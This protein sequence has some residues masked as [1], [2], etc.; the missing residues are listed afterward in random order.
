VTQN[1]TYTSS[2]DELHLNN[3]EF[4]STFEDADLQVEP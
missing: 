4:A 2:A 1:S 3:A